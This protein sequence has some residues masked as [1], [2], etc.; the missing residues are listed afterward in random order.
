M[1]QGLPTT[2]NPVS[3]ASVSAWNTPHLH[4]KHN[5]EFMEC[6]PQATDAQRDRLGYRSKTSKITVSPERICQTSDMFITRVQGPSE[7]IDAICNIDLIQFDLLLITRR[8]K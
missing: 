7:T 8:R 1:L 2:Q 4:P 3:G 5:A 6:P